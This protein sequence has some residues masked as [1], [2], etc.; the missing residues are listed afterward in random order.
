MFIFILGTF[1][2][3]STKLSAV[4]ADDR[5]LTWLQWQLHTL[6]TACLYMKEFVHGPCLWQWC[7]VVAL[8]SLRKCLYQSSSPPAAFAIHVLHVGVDNYIKSY[9]YIYIYSLKCIST[10]YCY[11]CRIVH[12]D[13]YSHPHDHYHC[14]H[15]HHD[16]TVS[17]TLRPS[18]DCHDWVAAARAE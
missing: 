17:F 16:Y 6:I 13:D 12:H 5:M 10:S 4:L 2:Q 3:R 18:R 8:L 9:T 1:C 14:H 15:H 11:I 7:R